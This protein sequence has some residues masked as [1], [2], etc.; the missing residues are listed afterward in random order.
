MRLG[1]RDA[2][3]VCGGG[4]NS[5]SLTIVDVLQ[6]CVLLDIDTDPPAVEEHHQNGDVLQNQAEK[7]HVKKTIGLMVSKSFQTES[8]MKYM[9]L[10]INTR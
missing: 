1:M 2:K 7:F 8:I 9:L 4:W 3:W 6:V 5:V 10:A